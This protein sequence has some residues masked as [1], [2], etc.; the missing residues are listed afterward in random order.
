M[1]FFNELYYNQ[2]FWTAILSWFVAQ[3]IKVITVLVSEKRFDFSRFVGS[4]GMPSSHSSFVTSL[5]VMIGL[6]NGFDSEGFAICFVLA[7]VVMYD[8]SGVRR[9]A[10]KQASILNQ[11]IEHWD[12]GPKIQG[13]RLKELIGHTPFEVVAGAALGIFIAIIMYM[14]VY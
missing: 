9:A 14:F 13:E 10:G 6:K 12:E 5:A 3:F 1:T 7:L 2:A 11:I 8:A 4:G